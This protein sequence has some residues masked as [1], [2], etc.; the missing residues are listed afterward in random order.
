MNLERILAISGKPGLYALKMQT[1][2]G[3]VAES[4]VDGKKVTV[5]M[6]SNVSLLSEISVYTY[7]EE[8]PLVDVMSAIAKKE[9]GGEAPRL[10]DDKAALLAYFGAVL[11]DYDQDRVYPSDVKKILN[12]YNI[13]QA[14]GLVV[15]AEETTVEETTVEEKPKKTRAT[16]AKKEETAGEKEEKP[17]KPRATKKTKSEE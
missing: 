11:P 5:G 14:K 10:K 8:K 7:T 16:K 6:Q 9:N 12:W 3:F 2:T 4:L 13:L 17:K 15:L 1:R